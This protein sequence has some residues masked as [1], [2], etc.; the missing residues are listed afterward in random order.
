MFK[1][2][3]YSREAHGQRRRRAGQRRSRTA[4]P[5]DYRGSGGG[6]LPFW[7]SEA[8][9]Q[10]LEYEETAHRVL[11]AARR[12]L[13]GRDAAAASVAAGSSET[14][15]DRAV[16]RG[17]RV[18]WLR[19]FA[20][21]VRGVLGR[22]DVQTHDVVKE[23]IVPET[24]AR[25]C[26]YTELLVSSGKK[27]EEE[28]TEDAMA[29]TAVEEVV[30]GR[31][32]AFVSHC[33]NGCFFDLVAAVTHVFADTDFVWIDVFA[34]PQHQN[35][36]AEDLDF[37]PVVQGCGALLLYAAH[38]PTVAALGPGQVQDVVD[39]GVA[40]VIS[41]AD[42]RRCAFWRVWCLVEL[43]AALASGIPVVMLVGGASWSSDDEIFT[44][45]PNTAMLDNLLQIVNVQEAEATMPADKH[46]IMNGVLPNMDF[47]E[48]VGAHCPPDKALNT[49]ANGAI[50]GS[51]HIMSERELLQACFGHT[52]NLL[53]LGAPGRLRAVHAAAAAGLSCPLLCL[54]RQASST[55]PVPSASTFSQYLQP[56]P[57]PEPEPEPHA[58][59]VADD[60]ARWCPMARLP[61]TDEDEDNENNRVTPLMRAASGGH[62]KAVAL[63]LAARANVQ[64]KDSHGANALMHAVGG[65][66]QSTIAV[67]MLIQAGTDLSARMTHGDSSCT[68]RSLAEERKEHAP[69]NWIAIVA[70]ERR[71][72]QLAQ[73]DEWSAMLDNMR[74]ETLSPRLSASHDWSKDPRPPRPRR[75]PQHTTLNAFHDWSDDPRPA[76]PRRSPPPS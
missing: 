17:V 21:R 58:V 34:I 70:A 54:L 75:P 66:T 33:W 67:E 22:D 57:A 5:Q 72:D 25:R 6:A 46:K 49:L 50:K 47:S 71:Q 26:R 28:G 14:A 2:C 36:S 73:R 24:A 61:S 38:L 68:A 42:R 4:A 30:V 13:S 56:E 60:S 15:A 3:C 65:G 7:D 55:E 62:T 43:G 45:V 23:I 37:V 53:E 32:V 48:A 51:R 69:G 8:E 76:R 12:K 52:A 41:E 44:F 1:G 29:A 63:L 11:E 39:Q 31:S 74:H 27:G 18:G 35:A 10:R 19:A 20:R 16:R 9:A 40:Q 59:A 64:E